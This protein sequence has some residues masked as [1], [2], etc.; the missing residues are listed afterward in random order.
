MSR[1]QVVVC[2]GD[3]NTWGYI[4]ITAERLPRRQRWPGIL[5]QS[6]G[7]AFHVIEEGLNGRTTVFDEPFRDGRNA[8]NTLLPLLES[9]APLDLLILMLGTNDL[10]H[11]LNISAHES[12]R[13]LSALLQI[14]V[15]SATGIDKGAPKILVVAP[16]KMGALSGLMAH[17]FEGAA[18]RSAELPHHYAQTC[19]QFGCTFL[20]ANQEVTVAG[21]GI[22]LNADGHRRLAL[23]L[24]PLVKRLIGDAAL[25]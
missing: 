23:A 17:H 19:A 3:S 25:G 8:R 13:G 7:D 22:H 21:D 24:T 5:Q 16:P 12:A 4:P 11:H 1:E 10:K 20:D 18:A 9:H 15:N 6:L 2:F 14:A